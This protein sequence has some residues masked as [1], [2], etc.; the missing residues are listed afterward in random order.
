MNTATTEILDAATAA[1]ANPLAAIATLQAPDRAAIMKPADSAAAMA[2][3]ITITSAVDRELAVEE[4]GTIKA[5]LKGL[6][7]RRRTITDPL[8]AATNA[9]NALFKP[10]REAL[11]AAEQVIKGKVLTYDQAEAKRLEDERKAAEEK[12]RKEREAAAAAAAKAAEEAEA[13]ARQQRA[14]AEAQAAAGNHEAAAALELAAAE[15][16]ASA[17]AQVAEVAAAASTKVI[18][19]APVA[20]PKV[21][22]KGTATRTKWTA[23]VTNLLELVKHVANV[24]PSLINLLA[25]DQKA[26]DKLASALEA[27]LKVPGLKAVSSQSLSVR[28]PR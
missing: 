16:Q 9:V 11:E 22:G 27:Q 3:S 26:A 1:P 13:A 21:G 23:E 5:T 14:A 10:A 8:N 2:A 7:E 19:P 15:Q 28:A 20:S 4:L 24:D 6:D 12:A 17:A 18:I 25:V